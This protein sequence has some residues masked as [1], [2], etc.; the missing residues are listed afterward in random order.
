MSGFFR[1]D[2]RMGRISTVLGQDVLVLRRFEGT[3]HL[4][5]LFDYSADC[6]A[7]TADVDFDRLI[8]THA[9]V[10]LTTKEGARPFDGIVTEARWLGSG[11]NGHRYRLRLRPWAFLASLRRNQRIFHNKTVV[12]ILTE[13]LSAY[14]DAGA[15]TVELANDYPELEYTVQYRESDLAFACRM[16]ERHGISYHFRHADGAHEMVLT[17]QVEA[18]DSIGARPFRP[19]EGHHQEEVSHFRAWR[20]ARRITTGAIRLTDYN[21]KTPVAAMETDHLGDAAYEQGQI[22]SFDWPG[23]YLDQGRGRVVAE[24]RAAGE[25][26]Q[27]RRFEAEGDIV[28][29]GAG[30]RVTLSGDPVPGTGGEYMC[31]SARH[32]YTADNYGSGG[33][34]DGDG[35]A[36]DGQYVLMPVEAPLL[37]EQKTARADV[38]GPQT[39][40]VVGEGEIDCDEYGRILVRF[41]WDLDEAWSMRCRVSQSWAGAGWGGMVIPRIGMEVVVEFLDGDPDKPLVTGCVYNGR[42]PVPY[43]LPANK[44]VSTFKSDTHQGAGYNEF[45]FEDEKDREEVFMH[46]Q[47]DHNTI[48]END[49]SHSIGHDRSKSVGN[50]QSEAIGHD[51]TISVGNDHRE[52]IGQDMY[53][54]VGRNQQED[55]GKD[56]IHRVGN[57]HKQ[58]VWADHLYEVGRN[59]QG[60][61]AG[62]YVLDVG[63]SITNNTGK[64]TLM[65]FEKFQIK[66]PGGKITIDGS[67][68]TLEAANIRLK[69]NVSVGGSGSA[70]VPT[71]KLAA[72]EGLP[73]CE[74]CAAI[75]E[76]V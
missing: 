34:D 59:Y 40:T 15:L 9:T 44:T 10:T 12:E 16:M 71:L 19:A 58:S 74:E 62:K 61:V 70:Q 49:E 20:P 23:D 65:A 11:D 27:D 21:F 35:R 64:H 36:Y 73:L 67:G 54:T 53:Y 25:R 69:G 8:G 37:P 26:G 76:D 46:A 31:L 28:A 7:A 50:D 38:R 13:L 24:L 63:T 47:K 66:G 5:A 32:S 29:L 1:Q 3:D 51:K 4:N 55:Y 56:H 33:S 52:T 18:H 68:I 60:E 75:K 48:I 14:A 41:H 43:D 6:L 42:N 57:I 22:E 2:A 72:K 45:R 39:A 17:D 30:L